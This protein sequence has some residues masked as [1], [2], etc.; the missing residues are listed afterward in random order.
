MIHEDKRFRVPTSLPRPMQEVVRILAPYR[1]AG[2]AF[3]VLSPRNVRRR[4]AE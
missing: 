4:S 3:A 1:R 2:W